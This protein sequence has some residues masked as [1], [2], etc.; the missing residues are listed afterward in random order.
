MVGTYPELRSRMTLTWTDSPRTVEKRFLTKFSSIQPSISPILSPCQTSDFAQGREMVGAYHRVLAASPDAGIGAAL[1]K[2]CSLEPFMAAP[3][4]GAP[5][6][7]V[8]YSAIFAMA[9]LLEVNEVSI[10]ALQNWTSEESMAPTRECGAPKRRCG[11]PTELKVRRPA[12]CAFGHHMPM[13]DAQTVKCEGNGAWG[14]DDRRL[15]E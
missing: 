5:V 4:A 12:E 14:G 2:P 11:V 9:E 6:A 8:V 3:L 15:P 10:F 13:K 1:L 7:G